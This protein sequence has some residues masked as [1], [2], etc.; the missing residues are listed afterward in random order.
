VQHPYREGMRRILIPTTVLIAALSLAGCSAS[1]GSTASDYSS[2]Q[3]NGGGAAAPEPAALG[4]KEGISSD[5]NVAA[6]RSVITTGDVIVTVDKPS[7]AAKEAI[8]LVEA[9][10]G[11]VDAEQENA[12]VQGDSGS[13][14]LTLRIPSAQLTATL[15]KL[16]A[17]GKVEQVSI[18]A[19][20]V[21]TEVQ[22]TDARVK[23]LQASVDRLVILLAKAK[24]TDTLVTIETALTQRQADLESLEAQQRGL[25]DQTSM[26]TINLNL[27]SKADAPVHKPDNFLTGLQTG[28]DS[29]VGFIA[30]LVVVLGVLLPWIVFFAIITVLSILIVRRSNRRKAAAVAATTP[31]TTAKK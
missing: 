1:A 30:G 8:R 24:S 29:F 12:P 3:D 5:G 13:A 7:G 15:E 4:T 31:T 16:K 9:V 14:T 20:D 27:I 19:T 17:L 18:N 6:D 11:R 21:T 28:W 25:T 10:G 22:D 26:S 2:A 23:A